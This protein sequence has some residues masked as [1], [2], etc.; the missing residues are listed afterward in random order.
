MVKQFGA[1]LCAAVAGCVVFVAAT[2]SKADNWQFNL[3]PYVW[4]PNVN[5]RL[6][7][8]PASLPGAGGGMITC[9]PVCTVDVQVGPSNY[10]SNLNFA[11]QFSAAASYKHWDLATDF[12]NLNMT[13]NTGTVTDISGPLGHIT[14]PFHV[15]TSSRFVGTIWT[16]V[17]GYSLIRTEPLQLNVIGGFRSASITATTGYNYGGSLGIFAGSGTVSKSGGPFNWIG[18]LQGRANLTKKL[19]VP[20]EFDLGANTGVSTAQEYIGLG[21]GHNASA[22]LIYRNL[23]FTSTNTVFKVTRLSGPA[24]GYTF[25]F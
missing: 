17:G 9:M 18:G 16:L 25:R 23:M 13:V 10:L 5:A 4:L 20:Y 7:F 24:I 14:I 8:N 6:Q 22:E 19:F 3:T 12:M 15:S 11:T 21:Y 1:A 2:P